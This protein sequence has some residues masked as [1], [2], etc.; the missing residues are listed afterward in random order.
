MMFFAP[1]SADQVHRGRPDMPPWMGPP[2]SEFGAVVP[3]E[4]VVARSA[5]VV[6]VLPTVRAFRSG[7]LFD[8]E[9]AGRQG[10]MSGDDWWDLQMSS[11]PVDRTESHGERLPDKLLRLGI[12]YPDGTKATTLGR[13]R[14]PGRSDDSPEGPVLTWT[15]GGSGAGRHADRYMF[16]HFGLWLWP[17]PPSEK[18]EFAVEWPFAGIDL[19]M[20]ELEGSA[21][22]SAAG[23]SMRYWPEAGES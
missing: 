18:M 8:V 20:A 2:E 11:V 16:S 3:V 5:N 7:C 1:P 4:R 9:V 12:R 13:R 15:P 10:R 17:L 14:A 6:I 19:T 22:V 21:I 23:R